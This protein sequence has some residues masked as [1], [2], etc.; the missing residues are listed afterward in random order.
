MVKLPL[1]LNII[2][3]ENKWN[4]SRHL[5]Q[6]DYRTQLKKADVVSARHHASQLVRHLA[7]LETRVVSTRTNFTSFI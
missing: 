7:Q 2:K 1:G 4:T 5:T 6:R 3:G